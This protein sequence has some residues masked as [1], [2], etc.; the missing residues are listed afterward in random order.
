MPRSNFRSLS[1]T[2][3]SLA[4]LTLFGIRLGNQVVRAIPFSEA[5]KSMGYDLRRR[6]F[7][8]LLIMLTVADLNLKYTV[9]SPLDGH[10]GP[11][12]CVR[13]KNSQIREVKKG[14]NNSRCSSYRGVG[15]LIEN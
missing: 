13:L 11:A 3:D 15:P 7:C 5:L 8:T 10:L 1:E 2:G 14:R 12:L 6:N 9:K 4:V